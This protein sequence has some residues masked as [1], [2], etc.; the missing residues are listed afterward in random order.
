MSKSSLSLLLLLLSS[1]SLLAQAP[2]AHWAVTPTTGA[3]PSQRRENP[4]AASDTHLYVFGGRLGNSGGSPVNELWAFDGTSWS[5]KTANNAAGSPPARDKA[6]VC[7]DPSRGKL[8][9]FGGESASGALL[10][11]TWEWDP[12]TNAWSQIMTVTNPPARRWLAIGYHPGTQEVLLFGGLDAAGVHLNDTWSL[13]GGLVWVNYTPSVVPSTRR[14]HSLVTRPDFGDLILCAGQDASF[15]APANWRTD[16]FSWNGSDWTLIPTANPP[17]SVVANQA[18]YDPFRQRIVMTGGQ[19]INGGS[20]TSEISEFDCLAN[21]WIIRGPGLFST[22]DPVIG[23]ISR[24]FAGF[25]PSLGKIF[26]ISG[27]NPSGTG[28]GP[29]VTCEYQSAPVASATPVGVGGMGLSG[30]PVLLEA[31]NRPWIGETLLTSA[32]GLATSNSIAIGV[33]GFYPT[34]VPLSSLTPIGLPGPGNDQLITFDEFVTIANIGGTAAFPVPVPDFSFLVG[35]VVYLQVLQ[36]E[37]APTLALSS[38]NALMLK[39]GM[40]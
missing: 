20:P 29:T 16:V 5:L 32:S 40:K 7:W 15:T 6:G 17:A 3:A 23:R 27:Q 14:Q 10:D 30:G 35:V 24:Y 11:D 25:V 34:S 22:A 12:N 2:G 19:G 8:I 21:D 37:T 28:A 1:G 38:S 31:Q 18:V 13:V 4:G 39:L 9:V 26:K 33:G 36:V